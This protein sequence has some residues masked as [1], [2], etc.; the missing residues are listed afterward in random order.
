MAYKTGQLSWWFLNSTWYLLEIEI[1][2]TFILLLKYSTH[3]L[4]T[5]DEPKYN[6]GFGSV[7]FRNGVWIPFVS[8]SNGM[9]PWIHFFLL[10]IELH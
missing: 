10:I 9:F 8:L 3:V 5:M 4:N 2:T 7:V 6:I 1:A